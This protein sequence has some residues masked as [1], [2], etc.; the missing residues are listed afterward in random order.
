MDNPQISE[1]WIDSEVVKSSATVIP[2]TDRSFLLGDG[3]FETVRIRGKKV[4]NWSRHMKRLL[5]GL[6]FCQFQVDFNPDDFIMGISE[7][8]T[9]AGISD[10]VARITISRGSDSLGYI[11]GPGCKTFK[12]IHLRPAPKASDS[13]IRSSIASLRIHSSD[14]LQK[15]KSTSRLNYVL[16]AMEAKKCGYEEALILNESHNIVE[17]ASGNFFGYHEGANILFIPDELSGA[18]P[19][20]TAPVLVEVAQSLGIK[21]KAEPISLSQL[22]VGTTLLLT[23]SVR[24]L[25]VISQIENEMFPLSPKTKLM[26]SRLWE[27]MEST[28]LP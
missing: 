14:P 13:P 8:L 26:E 22:P 27:M 17:W 3:L 23:N 7:L 28:S 1:F 6:E 12:T 21:L 9:R 4:F 16:A 20:T 10:A 24:G 5:D 25:Q 18:L 15:I 2:V 11:P 19:G